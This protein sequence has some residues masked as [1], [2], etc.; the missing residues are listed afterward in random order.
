MSE[1]TYLHVPKRCPI[2]PLPWVIVSWVR[3]L[4]PL[5]LARL[6]LRIGGCANWA[7]SNYHSAPKRPVGVASSSP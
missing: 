6:L 5:A 4:H 2:T 7:E 1:G 3:C